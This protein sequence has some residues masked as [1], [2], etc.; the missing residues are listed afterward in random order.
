MDEPSTTRSDQHGWGF[1]ASA[2]L[3]VAFLLT[4]LVDNVNKG[5]IPL[6]QA[7]TGLNRILGPITWCK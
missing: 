7:Q 2:G 6:E 1:S 3:P 5:Q 4:L